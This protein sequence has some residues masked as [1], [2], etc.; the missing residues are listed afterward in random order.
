MENQDKCEH[1]IMLPNSQLAG[2][3]G[4]KEDACRLGSRVEKKQEWI[5]H[6]REVV[7]SWGGSIYGPPFLAY[8]QMKSWAFLGITPFPL[9]FSRFVSRRIC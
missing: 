3:H 4:G 1:F 5:F 6:R 8:K 9:P 2:L 7:L